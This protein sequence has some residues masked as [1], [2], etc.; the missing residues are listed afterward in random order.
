MSKDVDLEHHSDTPDRQILELSGVSEMSNL[1]ISLNPRQ[2]EYLA[3]WGVKNV[4]F[5]HHSDTPDRQI[6]ELNVLGLRCRGGMG[7]GE[8]SGEGRDTSDGRTGIK[9]FGALNTKGAR[10]FRLP[11]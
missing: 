9:G 6:L 11:A 2:L 8:G 7:W 3:I 10:E 1:S 4:D 5:E